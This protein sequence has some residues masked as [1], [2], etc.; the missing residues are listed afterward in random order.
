MALTSKNLMKKI[1]AHV[2]EYGITACNPCPGPDAVC[3]RG[4]VLYYSKG[5]YDLWDVPPK[6]AARKVMKALEKT[7]GKRLTK[8]QC[9]RALR[10]EDTYGSGDLAERLAYEIE[11]KAGIKYPESNVQQLSYN[12]RHAL[13]WFDSAA[14]ML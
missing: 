10:A 3:P 9:G 5:R 7:A 13:K 11:L 1:R 4:L 14:E 6:G 12:K 8:L 2:A